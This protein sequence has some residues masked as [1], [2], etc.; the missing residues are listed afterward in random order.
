M[1]LG[2][3]A[4]E[5]A[6]AL[7]DRDRQIAELKSKVAELEINKK[8]QSE[9]IANEQMR[10][11]GWRQ[12]VLM[13]EAELEPLCDLS[14]EHVNKYGLSEGRGEFA[15]RVI[16]WHEAN[17][18]R[19]LAKVSE[20]EKEN[21]ALKAATEPRPMSEAPED[22]KIN[23]VRVARFICGAWAEDPGVAGWLPTPEAGEKG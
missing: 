16:E 18:S 6:G 15:V 14:N 2:K 11:D 8:E 12:Q 21:G 20:L 1:S 19:A 22:R 3:L 7:G 4:M 13:L 23:V 9:T 17:H 5:L 10:S